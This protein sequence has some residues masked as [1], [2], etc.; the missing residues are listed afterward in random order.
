MGSSNDGSPAAQSARQDDESDGTEQAPRG[1][2]GRILD[3]FNPSDSHSG[4]QATD[5]A[6]GATALGSGQLGLANLRKL[7]VDDVAIPKVEIAAVPLDIGK[8]DL[9]EAF[10][11]HGFSRLPVYKGTLDHPQGLVL[12]KDLALQHGFGAAGRF[13]L[14]RLLRP[15]LFAPPSMPAA[16]LLQKMQR[17]RVHMALVIDEY[18]GVDGLVTIEDL[19]ETVIGEIDD[20]H[21][22]VEG[23]L[24]KEE[25]PGVFLAQSVAPLDE[26]EA[27]IGMTLRADEDDA[28]I[29]TLGGLVFV[30]TG[31]VPARGE[32]VPHESGAEFEVVDADPRRIKR[33][34]VRLP[35][36]GSAKPAEAAEA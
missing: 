9:V 11:E 34:R 4:G 36:A 24:W 10:R 14:K 28:E 6:P 15:V 17:D 18:G 8:D 12:L 21:D 7:R 32:V 16:T 2:F 20:E 13:S 27:A 31:R 25:K 35:G 33:L 3:A 1:F 30:R 19:I 22:E 29:D 5:N 23:A 26:F